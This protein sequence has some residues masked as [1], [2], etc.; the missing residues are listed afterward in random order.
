MPP[1]NALRYNA[2]AALVATHGV[3]PAWTHAMVHLPLLWGSVLVPALAILCI[4]HG[5]GTK[6]PQPCPAHPGRSP[7]EGRSTRFPAR[8]HTPFPAYTHG[9]PPMYVPHSHK[10]QQPSTPRMRAQGTPSSGAVG[11]GGKDP[12]LGAQ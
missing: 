7:T 12:V 9:M 5:R 2:D 8:T 3:H 4:Q 11:W 1:M 10:L 6:D